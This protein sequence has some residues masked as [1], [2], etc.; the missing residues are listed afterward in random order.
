M[1]EVVTPAIV[2]PVEYLQSVQHQRP[3]LP[4][5]EVSWEE[6]MAFVGEVPE[7]TSEPGYAWERLPRWL[8]ELEDTYRRTE[9]P[10]T[11]INVCSSVPLYE[12]L[13]RAIHFKRAGERA[14][15]LLADLSQQTPDQA[16][17][18]LLR[19]IHQTVNANRQLRGLASS[20][21]QAALYTM[22]M[23]DL[24]D[25]NTK[26]SLER[27][28]SRLYYLLSKQQ[29]IFT[30]DRSGND[31]ESRWQIKH[32]V[33]PQDATYASLLSEVN[34][35]TPEAIA[36]GERMKASGPNPTD[37]ATAKQKLP[38]GEYGA[39]LY[40][41]WQAA[42]LA[43]VI[44]GNSRYRPARFLSVDYADP[45]E[46][47]RSSLVNMP[48]STRNMQ[49]FGHAIMS[50]QDRFQHIQAD[51]LDPLNVPD[52]SATLITSFDGW[53]YY[54][55]F[56]QTTPQLERDQMADIATEVV[57]GWYKKLAYGGKIVIFPWALQGD[58]TV[59]E[60]VLDQATNCLSL[61]VGHG[62]QESSF[63]IANLLDYMSEADQRIAETSS[64]VFKT[65]AS[66]IKVLIIEKPAA[67]LVKHHADRLHKR[68]STMRIK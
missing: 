29:D 48:E 21:L 39:D 23:F 57:Y 50:L 30:V 63:H 9:G 52:N 53:P 59:T 6:I 32:Q 12:G 27:L 22:N 10:I 64:P 7:D 36:A 60:P 28:S 38:V 2:D 55:S 1:T 24:A 31:M 4:V 13:L 67:S 44:A 68:V 15:D 16:T 46:I 58:H 26:L 18:P 5:G 54:N 17:E 35:R 49:L 14:S 37:I 61:L 47:A 42:Q 65:S 3:P 56:D 19:D 11:I 34:F 25:G 45:V 41:K 40:M 66:R 51:I 62:V 20:A 33:E 8:A 43:A